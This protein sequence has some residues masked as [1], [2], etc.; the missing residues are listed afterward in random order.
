MEYA[1]NILGT[2]GNTPLVKINKLA[3]EIDALVLAKYETFNPGNS[4]KDR[5]AVKMIEDAEAAG[6]L[7][8]GGTIIEGT[9][10][11]TGMGLA[12][13]AIVKGYK[14]VC[15][16][17]DKQSKEKVDI[18]RAVGSEVIVCPTDVEPDDPRSYYSTSKRLAEETPNSWYVNQYDNLSNRKAHYETTGPEI[19]KQTDGKITHFVVGV[20]TG[21]TISG[22][23]KYLKEQNPNIKVWGID[24]YGSVFKKYHETGEFDEK[25]IYPYVTEGIGEDIL[26]KNVDFDI[27]DGFT[28]VTDKDA[29]IYTQRL[30]KEE[31]MFLGNSAGAAM[32]GLLQLK[33]HFKKD[34][35]VVVLFHD[36]GSRYVGKMFNDDWMREKGYIE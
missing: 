25:E 23:G 1:E 15:V 29:A 11:N 33:E 28:K 26:P 30:A 31:G 9:S 2:I 24:T 22:V 17:A 12:L 10:G 16:M 18:L 8:P 36:H 35:V 20:G 4:V 32:K 5:M 7:K 34:D 21:G 3:E 19:W 13:V 27:I 14:M 6:L